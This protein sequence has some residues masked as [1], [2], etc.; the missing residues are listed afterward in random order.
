MKKYINTLLFIKWLWPLL[1]LSGNLI[2]QEKEIG[3]SEHIH[4]YEEH[5]GPEN[6]VDAETDLE[7]SFP[8]QGSILG[9]PHLGSYFQWKED[10][11]KKHGLKLGFS[12]ATMFTASPQSQM[13]SADRVNTAGVG[14]YVIE[15]QWT[16]YNRGEDWEGSFTAVLDGRHQYGG[17]NPALTP[18][19]NGSLNGIDGT[20]FMWDRPYFST[21]YW[22]QKVKQD[23]LWFRVGNFSSLMVLDFFRFKDGRTSFSNQGFT[24]P[25]AT[26]PIPAPSLAMA[27]NWK[28]IKDSELYIAGSIQ[29]NN[30]LAG[31][32]DLGSLFRNGEIFTGLEIG[33]HWV[34]G[35]GD[36]DHAHVLF[37]YSDQVSTSPL[38]TSSGWGMKVHGTK[39]WGNLV[40]FANYTYNTSIG[41]TM[42]MAT[43]AD[44]SA[45]IGLVYLQPFNIKGEVGIGINYSRM[46]RE[47]I[48][49]IRNPMNEKEQLLGQIFPDVR[50]EGQWVAEIYWKMLATPDLWITPGS[51]F[52]LNPT[53]N[54]NSDF[55][56]APTIKARYF[57]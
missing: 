5:I 20:F 25:V 8:E 48:R 53:M 16:A 46:N 12:Y 17:T 21:L 32:F 54:T 52:I 3:K 57:F 26:L 34:R 14:S 55:I 4:H 22:E 44:Q 43:Q 23:R 15:A 18:I 27:F 42:G 1:F 45:A 7:H 49:Q 40:S 24:N 9:K 10:L 11:Y 50:T 56:F 6:P 31:D 51:Q 39:Q 35:E 38:P 2:A 29:D 36:F 13:I 41:G 30:L 28:P 19:M 33:K 37:F 47:R